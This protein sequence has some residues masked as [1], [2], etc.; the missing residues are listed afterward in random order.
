MRYQSEGAGILVMIG[1]IIICCYALWLMFG[2]LLV[3]LWEFLV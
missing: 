3:G 1:V 2:W